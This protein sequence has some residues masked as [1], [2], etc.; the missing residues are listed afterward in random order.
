MAPCLSPLI[1]PLS[2]SLCLIDDD[3]DKSVSILLDGEESTME[4]VDLSDQE[5]SLCLRKEEEIIIIKKFNAHRVCIVVPL[6]M[7]VVNV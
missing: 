7:S 3:A 6:P 5:V 4:F 1:W 2:L